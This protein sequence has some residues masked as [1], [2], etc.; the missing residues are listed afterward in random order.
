MAAL[1]DA[2]RFQFHT[3]AVDHSDRDVLVPEDRMAGSAA[4]INPDIVATCVARIG[5]AET[6]PATEYF[7]DSFSSDGL[8]TH[9]SRHAT[10]LQRG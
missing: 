9:T 1:D 10:F 5:R 6:Q 4:D 7:L 3:E 2:L 8:H